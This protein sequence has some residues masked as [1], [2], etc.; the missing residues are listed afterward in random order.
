MTIDPYSDTLRSLERSLDLRARQHER[1]AANIANRDTP[2]YRAFEIDLAAA[3]AEETDGA[4]KLPL[5]RTEADHLPAV[6]AGS[7]EGPPP[8]RPLVPGP[9]ALRG[10]G[11][12]VDLDR[13]MAH[14]SENALM[15]TA[16][17]RMLADEYGRIRDAIE[18]RTA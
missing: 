1:I 15:Y 14:L 6:G 7:A 17:A 8:L 18:E 2:G 12:T 16:A 4:G 9:A 5:E 10:D 13:E 3:L 11:N